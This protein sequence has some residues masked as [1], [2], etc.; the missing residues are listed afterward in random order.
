MAR[1][2]F[3]QT[4]KA[5]PATSQGAGGPAS[6]EDGGAAMIDA[7]QDAKTEIYR[8]IVEQAATPRPGV[9]ELM[10]AALAAPDRIA[11]RAVASA[12]RAVTTN[13]TLLGVAKAH[14]SISLTPSPVIHP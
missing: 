14:P 1:Y 10:D 4:A 9:L 8:G 6:Y 11:V 13:P 3:E 7:L 12:R 2:F 5:W